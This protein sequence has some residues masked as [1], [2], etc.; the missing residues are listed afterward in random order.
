MAVAIRTGRA[1]CNGAELYYEDWGRESDPAVLLV[2]GMSVQLIEWPEP[3]CQHLVDSGFRVIRFDNREAGLSSRTTVK[4]PP[5]ILRSF[6]RYKRGRPVEAPYTLRLLMR[7]A[8][9]LLDALDID[10]AHW[11]G[12]SMG[13]MISQLAAIHAPERVISLT[14]IMSSSNDPDLPMPR[15]KTLWRII[16]QPKGKDED[17]IARAFARMLDSLSGPAYRTSMEDLTAHAKQV[18]ARARRP[19]AG[20]MHQMALFAEGGW[21]E[22][23]KRISVPTLVIHGSGDPLVPV[24]GGRRCAAEIPGAQLWEIEGWG[25]DFPVELVDTLA[26]GISRHLI[27]HQHAQVPI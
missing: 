5:P 4:T 22:D 24:A 15:L 7:D 12:F 19:Y 10:R 26:H 20:P 17:A 14:S 16:R 23:L 27:D 21:R 8:L 13:G 25:H 11:V 1:E 3:L 18:L 2:C 6:H 9:A